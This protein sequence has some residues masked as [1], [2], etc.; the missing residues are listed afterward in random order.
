MI[1]KEYFTSKEAA[2]IIG[3]HPVTLAR[4]CKEGK[5]GFY[6]VGRNR[7]FTQEDIDKFFNVRYVNKKERGND[8]ER[9]HSDKDPFKSC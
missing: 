1:E 5:I 8:D 6:L 9:T 3:I 7:R 4:Y 2:E